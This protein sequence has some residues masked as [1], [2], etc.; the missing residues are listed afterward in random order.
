MTMR[1][2]RTIFP[3]PTLF[4]RYKSGEI[5]NDLYYSMGCFD[6]LEP[7]LSN[8]KDGKHIFMAIAIESAESEKTVYEVDTPIYMWLGQHFDVV[9]YI[10]TFG[11]RC[12]T[13]FI[14]GNSH[15]LA[16]ANHQNN[17]GEYSEIVM[18]SSKEHN[19]F[20]DCRA[21]TKHFPIGLERPNVA[22]D[23]L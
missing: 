22:V 7:I 19:G 16:V 18:K 23:Y 13:P 4:L 15:F 9:Q 1:R 5:E 14:V 3:S 21:H 8:R 6:L 17:Y 11:A 2:I 12:V 10:R 20:A